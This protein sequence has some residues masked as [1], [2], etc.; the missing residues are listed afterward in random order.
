MQSKIKALQSDFHC[1]FN[2][3]K[4]KGVIVQAG[5]N[6]QEWQKKCCD[7][8]SGNPIIRPPENT[9]PNLLS[10]VLK[11]III[12]NQNLPTPAEL[13]N[14]GAL[15]GLHGHGGVRG[16]H[17]PDDAAGDQDQA[18]L[19]SMM[20]VSFQLESCTEYRTTTTTT[21][22][23]RSGH[24]TSS[25]A[26]WSPLLPLLLLAFLLPQISRLIS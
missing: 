3:I 15:V 23:P 2:L 22:S 26:S 10:Q 9:S 20:C 8:P 5:K 16:A 18:L 11:I 17:L 25:S 14:P 21:L 13:S 4:R 24:H 12:S 19:A 1:L 7:N 6:G